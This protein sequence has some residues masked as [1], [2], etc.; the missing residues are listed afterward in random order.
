MMTKTINTLTFL[1]TNPVWIV[2]IVG[3]LIRLLLYPFAQVN[4]ADAT[5]RILITTAWIHNPEFITSGIWLPLHFYLMA[6]P[7]WL[8]QNTVFIPTLLHILL[9]VFTAVP[10]YKLT[11]RLFNKQGAIL[12]AWIYILAPVVMRDSF[13]ALAGVPFAFFVAWSFYYLHKTV[14][15]K[16]DSLKSAF[17]S[18]LFLTIAAGFR[19]EAWI[20]IAIFCLIIFINFRWK[21][22]F[23]FFSVAMIFPAFWMIGSYINHGDIL[24]GTRGFDWAGIIGLNE[25]LTL[26]NI[27]NRF[28]FFPFS[29]IVQQSIIPALLILAGIVYATITKQIYQKKYQFLIP[30]VLFMLIFCYK[31]AMGTLLTQHRFSILTIVLSIPFVGIF[32]EMPIKNTWKKIVLY[33]TIPLVFAMGWATKSTFPIPRISNQNAVKITQKLTTDTENNALILDFFGW[34]NTFFVALHSGIS[35]ER[36]FIADGYLRTHFSREFLDENPKGYLVLAEGVLEK[37]I[38][39]LSPNL[40]AINDF[41]KKMHVENLKTANGLRLYRYKIIEQY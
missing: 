5:S 38:T 7:I 34:D 15:D 22:L 35:H 30:F 24:H 6:L 27:R 31:A 19:Y 12:A 1:R 11:E 25:N 13:Q 28:L 36:I 17:L 3:L 10:I 20:L 21:N 2:C 14:F 26:A 18:G 39:V 8:F 4:D 29:W 37:N 41:S 33:G 32:F 40:F 16:P 9:A 23:V